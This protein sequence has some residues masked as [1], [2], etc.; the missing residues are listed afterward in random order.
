MKNY[1]DLDY[2]LIISELENNYDTKT[3]GAENNNFIIY[4][5]NDLILILDTLGYVKIPAN[6][7]DIDKISM[8]LR[9]LGY[10]NAMM[11]SRIFQ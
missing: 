6:L 3:L 11:A 2:K 10:I 4:R 7:C 5:E 9:D 1:L 8:I